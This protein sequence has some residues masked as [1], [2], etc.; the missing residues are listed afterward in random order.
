M[1]RIHCVLIGT[2]LII[3]LAGADGALAAAE[4]RLVSTGGVVTI[5]GS[6]GGGIV[7]MAVMAG[8]STRR[9]WDW[10][11]GA[12]HVSVSDFR[13]DSIGVAASFDDRFEIS[14]AEQRLG[15][16]FEL[17]SALPCSVRQRI[18]GAKLRLGGDLIYGALPQFSAGLQ[19]KKNGDFALARALGADDDSGLDAYFSVTRLVLDGPFDRNWLFN[20]TLR[21][22]RAN[23]TGLLGFGGAGNGDP[24]RFVGEVSTAVFFDPQWALGFEYRQK[25]EFLDA[26]GESDWRDLFVGWFPNTRV[27]VVLAYADL[28]DVAGRAD[29]DGFFLSVTG[30]FP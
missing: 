11:A 22:T 28:G 16:D 30:N 1:S 25:P 26:V 21:A 2:G 8:L 5:E 10:V 29:Q 7:P 23:E 18:V 14:L 13:L 4:G 9:G 6:A 27:N 20:G 12:A 17:P 19:W 24:Y 3:A 15:I